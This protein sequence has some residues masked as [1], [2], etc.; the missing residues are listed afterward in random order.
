M[1]ETEGVDVMRTAQ[2]MLD[3]CIENGLGY[4]TKDAPIVYIEFF[5]VIAKYLMPHENVLLAFSGGLRDASFGTPRSFLREYAFALT[6]Q[7]LLIG[8]KALLLGGEFFYEAP[9][10]NLASVNMRVS[11]AAVFVLFD[12]IMEQ[13]KVNVWDVDIANRIIHECDK[14]IDIYAS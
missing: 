4:R 9:L 11:N 10:S 7:R 13:F 6:G 5:D 3:Y 12:M 8:A 2:E 14:I 1:A